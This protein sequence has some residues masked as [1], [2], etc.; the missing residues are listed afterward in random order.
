MSLNWC[1][2]IRLLKN[3]R[4]TPSSV[5]YIFKC[6]WLKGWRWNWW[7]N[8]RVDD[9]R[10]KRFACV[11]SAFDT[12]CRYIDRIF[13]VGMNLSPSVIRQKN[14]QRE[15]AYDIGEVHES[16]LVFAPQLASNTVLVVGHVRQNL[17]T[18][19]Q[20]LLFTWLILSIQYFCLIRYSIGGSDLELG[21]EFLFA[22]AKIFLHCNKYK[23]CSARCSLD[24]VF[25]LCS[26]SRSLFS[27]LRLC[28]P[29]SSE[30]KLWI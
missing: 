18:T 6:I 19:S 13:Y 12:N 2:Y 11:N 26:L 22:D 27:P 28:N 5:Q 1:E 10:Q 30:L 29:F 20:M 15:Y 8:G 25:H 3:I 9:G 7:W 17:N 21:A 4:Y 23:K 24:H 14:K 16:R